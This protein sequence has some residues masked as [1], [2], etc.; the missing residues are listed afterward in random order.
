MALSHRLSEQSTSED[1][2][3]PGV[4][5]SSRKEQFN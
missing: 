3:Y 5:K 4:E 2:H 1:E